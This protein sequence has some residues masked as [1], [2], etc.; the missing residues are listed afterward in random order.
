MK[1]E[2]G[3]PYILLGQ[4]G[5]A[6][7]YLFLADASGLATDSEDPHRV[8]KVDLERAGKELLLRS[9]RRLE[10]SDLSERRRVTFLCG[11]AGT[12]ALA[13][14]AGVSDT[15]QRHA[16]ALLQVNLKRVFQCSR[17]Y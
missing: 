1:N 10:T 15:P 6:L 8:T 12:L 4:S 11:D 3:P 5:V 7:L 9:L 2:V 14:A 13:I 16:D 17:D